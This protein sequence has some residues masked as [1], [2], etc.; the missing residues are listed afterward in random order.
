MTHQEN[1]MKFLKVAAEG[2][3]GLTLDAPLTTALH[4]RIAGLEAAFR[5]WEFD[6]ADGA[7]QR[8]QAR[9][10]AILKPTGCQPAWLIAPNGTV[11]PN[12]ENT[13]E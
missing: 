8:Y 11:Y 6:L 2:G 1:A 9:V 4:S 5:E 7:N 13:A 3:T 10:H 12:P